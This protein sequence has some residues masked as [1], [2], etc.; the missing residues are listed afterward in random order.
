MKEHHPGSGTYVTICVPIHVQYITLKG[1]MIPITAY[2]KHIL[3][4]MADEGLEL[5]RIPQWQLLYDKDEV[6]E[7]KEL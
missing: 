5:I 1:L 4:G 3:V 6:D 7:R 2:F